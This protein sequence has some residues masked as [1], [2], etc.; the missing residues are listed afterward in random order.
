MI[1]VQS[2]SHLA[3]AFA[4][5]LDRSDFDAAAAVLAPTCRHDLTKASLTSERTLLGPAAIIASYRWHD[6]R[7]HRLFDHV[8]YFSVI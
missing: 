6:Q 7:E 1:F 2:V 8:E 5:A 3:T 4:R